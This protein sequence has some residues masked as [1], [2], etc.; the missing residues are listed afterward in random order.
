MKEKGVGSNMVQ[1]EKFK[2]KYC[3]SD[4]ENTFLALLVQAGWQYLPGR[5]IPRRTQ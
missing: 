2:G 5:D 3:E 4:F 1:T